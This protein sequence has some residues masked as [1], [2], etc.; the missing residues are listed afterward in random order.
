MIK[1]K[2]AKIISI[3]FIILSLTTIV[4]S[5]QNNKKNHINV[6]KTIRI[7]VQNDITKWNKTQ[8][9]EYLEDAYQIIKKNN[10]TE[11]DEPNAQLISTVLFGLKKYDELLTLLKKYQNKHYSNLIQLTIYQTN[12]FK[13]K[14]TPKAEIY[15][16][17]MISS[18]QD[19]IK[20]HPKDT[21]FYPDLFMLKSKIF[22]Q[23]TLLKEIDSL[24]RLGVFN[25]VIESL[26]LK[27]M[28]NNPY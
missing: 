23:K 24:K 27:Y 6:D 9:V 13:Y 18:I 11:I 3:T 28:E 7:K 14:G 8:N 17:K 20:L 26:I 16:K 10:M 15:I 1:M 2:I 19:S 5:C 12:Y 21:L 4:S 22:P 25:E